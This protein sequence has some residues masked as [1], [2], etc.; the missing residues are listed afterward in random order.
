MYSVARTAMDL[1]EEYDHT[2]MRV[3]P[4]AILGC[5]CYHEKRLVVKHLMKCGRMKAIYTAMKEI[6][7]TV[8]MATHK[9]LTGN[10]FGAAMTVLKDEPELLR[11]I[12]PWPLFRFNS[13][14]EATKEAARLS[15]WKYGAFQT[16]DSSDSEEAADSD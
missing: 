1:S 7:T 4:C 6:E 15:E 16:Q 9:K 5:P 11:T 13:L 2:T 12:A 14:H 8:L 3:V 10:M